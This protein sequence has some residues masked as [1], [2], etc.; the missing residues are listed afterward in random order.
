MFLKKKEHMSFFFFEKN[1]HALYYNLSISTNVQ[2]EYTYVLI[3]PWYLERVIYIK[4]NESD[5]VHFILKNN[6]FGFE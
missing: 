2:T 5:D 4:K 1:N 3:L 6:L